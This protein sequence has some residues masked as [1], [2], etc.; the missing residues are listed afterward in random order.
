MKSGPFEVGGLLGL[1]EFQSIGRVHL[2]PKKARLFT[3]GQAAQGLFVLMEGRAKLSVATSQGRSVIVR[4]G[5]PGE[6]L[7]LSAVLLNQPYEAS[8]WTLEPARVFHVDRLAFLRFLRTHEGVALRVM[9]QVS[10]EIRKAYKH[11]VSGS[12]ATSVRAKLAGFLLDMADDE[13]MPTPEGLSFHLGLTHEEISG[14]IGSSRETVSRML[15]D[16]RKGGL[17]RTDGT[18]VHLPDVN[19]LRALLS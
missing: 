6:A 14:L 12:V 17:I 15:S 2:H 3:A 5:Q 9:K 13:A 18:L 1:E 16:F 11:I 4:I 10:L 8:A 7:G 19:Q